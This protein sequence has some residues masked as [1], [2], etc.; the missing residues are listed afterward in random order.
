[1]EFIG[2]KLQ[3]CTT[4]FVNKVLRDCG[5]IQYFRV[6]Q[7]VFPLQLQ[8]STQSSSCNVDHWPCR[9]SNEDLDRKILQTLISVHL[10]SLRD[11]HATLSLGSNF[12]NPESSFSSPSINIL[13]AHFKFSL[14][15]KS[16]LGLVNSKSPSSSCSDTTL[17]FH[18]F[19]VFVL[20]CF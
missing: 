12:L 11:I 8:C 17:F 5:H 14:H 16:I 3:L 20:F 18:L 2:S 7:A 4:C 19:S 9:D 6:V 15:Y 10:D 13:K 1:M